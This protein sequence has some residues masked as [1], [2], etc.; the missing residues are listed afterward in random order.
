MTNQ[1]P[2][3]DH[4]VGGAARPTKR[5][6][7]LAYSFCEAA[8]PVIA[9]A[10]G[11]VL[12]SVTAEADG[13]LRLLW[14]DDRLNVFADVAARS[15]AFCPADSAE[16]AL[17]RA[18]A[19][20]L[21]SLAT[22]WPTE[23]QPAAIGVVTDGVGVVVSPNDPSPSSPGWLQRHSLGNRPPVPIIPLDPL[24]PGGWLT[25]LSAEPTRH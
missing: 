6:Q 17:Q 24:G 16:G 3:P 20:L 23:A 13:Q 19:A 4:Q 22:R 7:D 21:R 5:L 25:E 8:R 15:D 1:P 9:A 2:L 14:W 18:G 12:L 11:R 10:G